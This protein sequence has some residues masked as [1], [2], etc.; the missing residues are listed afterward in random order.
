MS[1]VSN[2]RSKGDRVNNRRDGGVEGLPSDEET[3]KRL[4]DPEV[5][6]RLRQIHK[7]IDNGEPLSRGITR[8]EL[9][10]F[11]REQRKHLDT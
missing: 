1:R 7:Q 3:Q 9:P 11:L 5:Q 6:E 8:E 10:D 4:Q 2:K